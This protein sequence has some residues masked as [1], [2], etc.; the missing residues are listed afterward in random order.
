MPTNMLGAMSAAGGAIPRNRYSQ[1]GG[2][3][4]PWQTQKPGIGPS[5]GAVQNAI[6]QGNQMMKPAVQPR[7]NDPRMDMNRWQELMMGGM[8]GQ[9]GSGQ[10]GAVYPY[11][12]GGG[13][14]GPRMMNPDQ[15]NQMKQQYQQ[16]YQPQQPQQPQGP[17][18]PG[19]RLGGQ[20]GKEQRY[21]AILAARAAGRDP[22]AAAGG[23][24][25]PIGPTPVA[26][27]RLG[28]QAGKEQRYQAILQA[29][30]E[31]RDPYA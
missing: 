24:D 19:Q 18:V 10:M 14:G 5:R 31:G 27:G 2:G 12:G 17:P 22:Y 15:M 20:A 23:V 3:K 1:M 29:R 16:M 21:Q 28:G 11:L 25:Q 8:G 9:M 26:Q 6:G 4:Q 7:M 30:R 13:P